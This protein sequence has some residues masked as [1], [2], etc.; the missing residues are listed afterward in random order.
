MI[1]MFHQIRNTNKKI[2]I[3]TNCME[4]LGLKSTI[5]EKKKITTAAQQWL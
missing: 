3:M 1:I 2:K 4:I 5:I